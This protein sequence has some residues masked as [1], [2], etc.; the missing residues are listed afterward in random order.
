MQPGFTDGQALIL[1]QRET[2]VRPR[3]RCF[4]Q[5]IKNHQQ[6]E[7]PIL[8]SCLKILGLGVGSLRNGWR[9]N[10]E[11]RERGVQGQSD[12]ERSD[13]GEEKPFGIEIWKTSR[14][15]LMGGGRDAGSLGEMEEISG[16]RSFHGSFLASFSIFWF[17][18]F[19]G[20][21]CSFHGLG[22]SEGNVNHR[23]TW[24]YKS[25]RFFFED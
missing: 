23:F 20:R 16:R 25:H 6:S 19:F 12:G 13:W 4:K 14:W 21:D 8:E 17:Y 11:R 5:W 24:L 3:K 10:R 15:G 1:L 2:N 22:V 18:P 9:R 7:L